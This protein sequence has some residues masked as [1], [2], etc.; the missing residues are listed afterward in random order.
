M[1]ALKTVAVLKSTAGSQVVVSLSATA[2]SSAAGTR[3]A[4]AAGALA[5]ALAAGADALAAGALAAGLSDFPSAFGRTLKT[6]WALW[7]WSVSLQ[8]GN[9]AAFR[10]TRSF[11]CHP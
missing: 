4:A 5:A 1:T 3:G 11:V 7:Y 2:G 10:A 9:L 6:R 8:T